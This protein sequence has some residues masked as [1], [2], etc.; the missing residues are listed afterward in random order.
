MQLQHA[1]ERTLLDLAYE[2]LH[3]EHTP[4]QTSFDGTLLESAYGHCESITA[5]NSRSWHLAARLLTPLT[6][7]RNYAGRAQLMC[8]ELERL[9]AEPALSADVFEVVTKS[10]P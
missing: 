4:V 3:G 8:A 2:A 7:W 6:K 9:A 10:L 1:W 5:I